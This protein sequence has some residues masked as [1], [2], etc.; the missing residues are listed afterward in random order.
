MEQNA[1]NMLSVVHYCLYYAMKLPKQIE[2]VC[3]P[4]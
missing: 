4:T 1:R 3:L 2:Q